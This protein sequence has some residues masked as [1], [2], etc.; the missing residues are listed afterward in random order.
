MK[1]FILSHVISSH[2]Q[3][4]GTWADISPVGCGSETP[5]KCPEPAMGIGQQHRSPWDT[6]LGRC[7]SSHGASTGPPGP[8]G[9]LHSSR[10]QTAG[11]SLLNT[12][13][14]PLSAQMNV[15][16]SLSPPATAQ[17]AWKGRVTLQ[18]LDFPSHSAP[19]TF[20]LFP[21]RKSTSF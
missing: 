18:H 15:G 3:R 1:K 12:G 5:A 9:Q 11:L 10:S 13:A 6:A 21:K 20:F 2:L 8:V 19:V 4:F 14:Q 17:R 16:V 7:K